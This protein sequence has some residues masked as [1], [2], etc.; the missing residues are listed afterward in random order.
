MS[1]IYPPPRNQSKLVTCL[2]LVV[3]TLS[4]WFMPQKGIAQ[5]SMSDLNVKGLT[6]TNL[7]G[8]RFGPDQRLYVTQQD[9][10]LYAFTV[11]RLAA[12]SYEITSTEKID[13]VKQIPNH[14]DDGQLNP[15]ITARQVTGILVTG[16][17]TKPVLYVGSSDSRIG[18]PSGDTN[19]DTNSGMVSRL[20]W[21]GPNAPS[22]TDFNALSNEQLWD[23]V[24]I[25]RG[26]PRSEEN[27]A[28]NGMQLATLNGK[29]YLFV[30]V[31]GFTNAGSPSQNF[32]KITEYALSSAVISID[33]TA[34]EALPIVGT[35]PHKHVYDIPTV[36]DPTRPNVNG[37][38]DPTAPG[39]NG[40]DV[41]DPFGGNDG[42]NQAKLVPGGPVQIFS[43]GYRNTYD[44]VITKNGRM[45]VTDNGANQ[46]WG[47]LP[48]NEGP[49]VLE[50]GQLVS[51][52]TNNYHVNELGQEL[53]SGQGNPPF[54]GQT[55]NN[56]DALHLVTG[57]GD[58]AQN[59]IFNYV[60]GSYY[61]GHPTPIRAN[62]AG[63]GLYTHFGTN[64]SNDGV[65]RTVK[66]NPNGTGEAADPSKAL[67]ADW[68]PVPLSM[69]NPV[70][71]DFR[72][73]GMNMANGFDGA[74]VVWPTNTNAIAEYTASNLN[75]EF[76]GHLIAGS[77]SQGG[78]LFRV[79][80]L[81]N[82]GVANSNGAPVNINGTTGV[83]GTANLNFAT[84]GG[85]YVL[86]ISCQGDDDIFPGTIWSAS[87]NGSIKI[88]EPSDYAGETG[89]G[90]VC[91]QPGEPGYDP[92]ADYDGDGYKN[93]DEID[94]QTNHCSSAQI[95]PDYD[96][97]FLSDLNDPDDDGDGIDDV[98]DLFQLD[99][100]NAKNVTV[101]VR[102]DLFN[103]GVGFFRLDL[104]GIMNNLKPD[105]NYLNWLDNPQEGEVSDIMG[106]A[107]GATTVH[108]GPGD[109]L[110]SLNTQQKGFHFGVNINEN[111]PEFVANAR[112]LKPF[113]IP[114]AGESYGAFVG[115]GDQDNYIKIVRNAGGIQVVHETN[116][117]PVM[118]QYPLNVP[119][120]DV[121]DIF[122]IVNPG[123]GTIHPAYRID[124]GE[125]VLLGT[126][127]A[128]SGKL[129]DVLKVPDQALAIG[130]IGTTGGAPRFASNYDY[131]Q[132]TYD[133]LTE[134]ENVAIRI[135]AGE[136]RSGFE[137]TDS[138]G[139][140]WGLDNFFVGGQTFPNN[141][142][143][144]LEIAG[145]NDDVLYRSERNG[146]SGF[147][148]Q[149]PVPNGAYTV[150]LHFAEIYWRVAV[151]QGGAGSRVFNV[152][153]EGKNVLS[154][155]DIYK[156]VGR[157]TAL[158]ESFVVEVTDGVLNINATS[159]VDRAK[160]SAIEVLTYDGDI[161]ISQIAN[162]FNVAG[163]EVS[164]SVIASGGLANLN[165][166]ASGLPAGLTIEPTNGFISGTIEPGAETG[167]PNNDGIYNI[168]VR[169]NDG[170]LS[171]DGT[172]TFAWT[173]LSATNLGTWNLANSN[174]PVAR[175]ES[176]YVQVG[177]RFYLVGGRG[178]GANI[179]NVAI[180][181]PFSD[182]WTQSSA[183]MP[184]EL[185][186]FQAVEFGGLIYVINAFTGSFPNETPV[187][188]IYI[189]DPLQDIWFKGGK[190]PRPRANAAAVVY[191]GK[192]YVAGG[193]TDGHKGGYVTWFDEYDPITNKWREMPDM[194]RYRDHFMGA[195][196]NNRLYAAGGRLSDQ[197]GNIKTAGLD[198]A[199]LPP[200]PAGNTNT[201]NVTVPAVDYFDFITNQWVALPASANIPTQRAGA[202][203]AVIGNELIVIGGENGAVPT[204]PSPAQGEAEA[205]NVITHTWRSL[206]K[207]QVEQSGSITVEGRHGMQA[208]TN[209][210]NIYI[211]AG[212]GR[213]G[214]SPLM[215]TQQ[216]FS[217]NNLIN[218]SG[219]SLAN[220]N[221]GTTNELKINRSQDTVVLVLRNTAPAGSQGVFIRDIVSSD[222]GFQI[223][224]KDSILNAVI[225]PGQSKALG[226]RYIAP[227]LSPKTG[228]LSV[229]FNNNAQKTIALNFAG[230]LPVP[231]GIVIHRVNIGGPQV[232]ALDASQGRPN[233]SVDTNANPSPFIVSGPTTIFSKTSPN[234]I[235][236]EVDMTHSSLLNL[237]IPSQVFNTE[238]FDGNPNPPSLRWEFPVQPGTR[239]AVRL[240]F[241]EIFNGITAPGQRVFNIAIN[242][243][244]PSELENL[245]PF[246]LAGG[247]NKAVIV[248]TLAE[249]QSDGV[250][251]VELIHTGKE[252]PNLKGIEIEAVESG[253]L[254]PIVDA[255]NTISIRQPANTTNLTAQVTDID[256][257]IAST[258]WTQISG[259]NTATIANPGSLS[260][261][262]S[263][264]V[265]GT[266]VFR[267]TAT[268]N[269]GA[270]GFAQVTVNVLPPNVPPIVNAGADKSI[271]LP[272]TSVTFTGSATDNDGFVAETVWSQISGPNQASISGVNLLNMTASNLILGEYVFR[273][274][275]TDN[276]GATAFDDV[277]LTVFPQNVPPVANAG[278][279]V[280]ITLPTNSVV[281]SGSAS[282]SDGV[283]ANFTWTQLSGPAG[284][285]IVVETI[286]TVTISNLQAGT[287]VFRLTVQDNDGATAFDDVTVTVNPSGTPSEAIIQLSGDLAFGSIEVNS[288]ANRVLTIS[289]TG[290]ATLSVTNITYPEGFSGDWTGGD[291]APG[292]N[293]TVNVTFNPT[294]QKAYSGNIT[295]TSNASSGTNTIAVSGT[296][297]AVTSSRGNDLSAT[298]KLF[299]NPVSNEVFLE[300]EADVVGEIQITLINP[301]GQRMSVQKVQKTGARFEHQLDT[302]DLPQGIYFLELTIDRFKAVKR[303]S[304]L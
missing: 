267:L 157:T 134:R 172:A 162:Q 210:G 123:A 147:E 137:Y 15:N 164:V 119:L 32:T 156:K 211:T 126:P 5:F 287:Y 216:I 67:P 213:R 122:F 247:S 275:A 226:I 180:Y 3:L 22:A 174:T 207:M 72:N 153:L 146:I 139:N 23:K 251:S 260:T 292:Q 186:S 25:I 10:T 131:F 7:T 102:L 117:V 45:Y 100:T 149:I 44:L 179:K 246:A 101:P 199:L 8:L 188:D 96:K 250:L 28:N 24:D 273:L 120:V 296:G 298:L 302:K 253:N 230:E 145:T 291:I 152:A 41:G 27:H 1:R 171:N 63:A 279:D 64:A 223:I 148:Y 52:V 242:N 158:V 17:L 266:Y 300:I 89:P 56:H 177:N 35:G 12:N 269:D 217:F 33:L 202:S 79:P 222:P 225:L 196:V 280:T 301:V 16:T 235:Q 98:V 270:N 159:L 151:L 77:S 87:Y 234:S 110:G 90:V 76:K 13:L 261:A 228:S 127:I 136:T 201:F 105:D 49:P 189:Y 93:F 258:L 190:I 106:G 276:D 132:A 130:M 133:L 281:L 182:S 195:V 259:P 212:S 36:D 233:W 197:D 220:G 55:V 176:A 50:N 143:N 231:P 294:E 60:P 161:S 43:P 94:N 68:P 124:D 218:P 248:T 271:K 107:V 118:Q 91:I 26:L 111:T 103:Q 46:G 66:F 282:D 37:I 264:L 109:A 53:G 203:V 58:P 155:F 241:A 4:A 34:I 144:T 95:P 221:L 115:N 99:S 229:L 84:V 80:I 295:V 193:L 256:G 14:N 254:S 237:N 154:N 245:D 165:Y 277:K 121:W 239:V 198:P 183:T 92:M 65:F 219:R 252:N 129:L 191:N 38:T 263:N 97:D 47:G 262:V 40:I 125:I 140:V 238:R 244:I 232:T 42:L 73:P 75:N 150:N 74:A 138:E 297:T 290:S 204:N 128:V 112:L 2:L 227:D 187:P 178:A 170:G 104:V 135:N 288:S 181:D 71:G 274:T 114:V 214:G 39:Y 160:I 70:E 81:A 169:V 141:I 54:N 240:L 243:V 62:P 20:T 194:P 82:G 185:H 236:G 116:G 48:E 200:L 31:G 249:I 285:V 289:N 11:N 166:S 59:N 278:E 265:L 30:S 286:E 61:A 167:G 163:D 208:I 293:V 299:P 303:F 255:G 206:T 173:V 21:I 283:I 272:V 57:F 168:T 268:D 88:L 51:K 205:L 78:R 18:G 6:L 257:T 304:K 29:K 108:W 19:L 86:G 113:H 83:L 284:A 9:G 69:A 215:T 142:S 175:D 192:I 184:M 85:G 209:N 224:F